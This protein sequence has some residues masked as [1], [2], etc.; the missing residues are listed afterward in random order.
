ML[1]ESRKKKIAL[2]FL[3]LMSAQLLSPLMASALTSGPAQPEMQKFEPAGATDLVD[4]FTGDLKYNI[5]L[6]EVGGYP[7]NLSYHSG[8]GMDEEASWVGTGWTLNPG[9]VNRTLRGLPDEFDGSQMDDPDIVTKEYSRK[10]FE[11]VAG[12]VVLKTTALAWEFGSASVNL[13]VY[14]DNYYGIGASIGASLGYTLARNSQT[15]LTAGLGISSDNR[16]G[17]SVN[18]SLSLSMNQNQSSELGLSGLSGSLHYNT[19]A[20]LKN[21]SLTA[22]FS[23]SYF[24]KLNSPL[25]RT[26]VDVYGPSASFVHEFGQS[27]TPTINVN[28]INESYSFSLDG[29]PTIFGGYIGIGGSGSVFKEKIADKTTKAPAYGYLNYLK[30]YKNENALLDFN[31]EK[32]GVFVPS[33]PSIA[34]PVA[35]YDYF[36]AVSQAGCQQF[37]PYFGGNYIVFDKRNQSSSTHGGAGITTGGGNLIK[38]GAR[39]D[40]NTSKTQTKKWT[41]Q[42]HYL[43]KGEYV[44]SYMP[45]EEPVYFKQVGEQTLADVSFLGQVGGEKTQQ[46]A[47]NDRQNAATDAVAYAAFKSREDGR[48]GINSNIR[49]EGR[50]I[51]NNVFSYLTAKQA[52]W[53]GVDRKIN[54]E[55]RHG[56]NSHRKKHHIS[57]VQVTDNEG[58]RMV[59]GIPVYNIQQDEVSFSIKKPEGAALTQARSTGL[60]AYTPTD[61]SINN[62]NGR[63][64]LFSKESLPAYP[65]SFLLTNILST[66]YVD[67]TGDGVTDDDLGTAVKFNYAKH[68]FNYKWRAPFTNSMANYNEGLQSDP[69]DDKASYVFGEKEVWYLKSIESKTMIAVFETTDRE[70]GLGV[71]GEAGGINTQQKLKKLSRIKLYSKADFLRNGTNAIPIKTVHFEYDYSLYPNILN[72]SGNPLDKNGNPVTPCATGNPNTGIGSDINCQKGKLTLKKVYFTFGT[73]TRGESNP[74]EFFYDTSPIN[75]IPELALIP[76]HN[77]EYTDKYAQRLTDRW[78]TYKKSFYNRTGVNNA[79][80]TNAEFPYV[81]QENDQTPFSEKLLNDKFASK[82]QLN[83]IITTTGSTITI[84]YESDDYAYVQDR[85]A[86]QMC[87]VKGINEV[88]KDTGLIEADSLVIELPKVLTGADLIGQFKNLYLKQNDGRLLDK[89]F[90]KVYADID[91][92]NHYEYINGYAELDLNG[93]RVAGDG[94][95]VSLGLKKVGTYNPV[96]KAAWQM[97]KADLPQYAYDYYD[98]TSVGNGKAAIRSII[99]A[100]GNLSELRVSF[101]ERAKRKGFANKIDLTK[102]MVRLNSPTQSK[103]GGGVRV[104]KVQI[105]DAW[106]EMIGS[107]NA[108]ATYGQ[109]YEYTDKDKNGVVYS[110][111][112]AAYEPHVGNEENPFHEPVSFTEKVHWGIDRYHFI[113]KPFG[114]SYFPA[115]EVGYSKVTVTAIGDDNIQGLP[116]R[117][118]GFAIHEYYTAKDFPTIVDYLPLDYKDA[119]NSLTLALFASV[120]RKNAAVS[121]GF[122][123][124]L[125]DMHGK[126][127]GERIFNKGGDLVSSSEYFYSVKDQNAATKELNNAVDVLQNDDMIQSNALIGVDVDFT[128]DVREST[129]IS[130]GTSIGAYIGSAVFII[131]IPYGGIN[132]N[133]QV[134]SDN[135]NSIATV[136]VIR[137]YGLLKKVVNTQNGSTIASENLLWDGQTGKVILSRTQNE[138]DDYTYAFSYPAYLAYDGMGAAYKNSGIVFLNFSTDNNG[139]IPF[140]YNDYLVPGDELGNLYDNKRGWVIKSEDDS[141]R[142]IDKE[143][144]YIST[145]RDYKLLRSGRRNLLSAEAGKIISMQDP[146]A[147]GTIDGELFKKKIID[148]QAIVYKEQWGLP[149]SNLNRQVTS[150]PGGGGGGGARMAA[151]ESNS[152]GNVCVNP[153]DSVINPYYHNLLGNWH[154]L[155]P[156]I[157]STT[158]KQVPGNTSQNGGTDIRN[159]GYFD[160]FSPFWSFTYDGSSKRILPITDIPNYDNRWLWSSKTIHYDAKGNIVENVDPLNRYNSVLYGF[161]ESVATAVAANARRNEIAFESFEDYDFDLQSQSNIPCPNKKHFDFNFTKTSGSWGNYAGIINSTFAH[162]GKYSY[163]IS[164]YFS[165]F[166]ELGNAAPPSNILGYDIAG[167]Y[168]LKSNEMA[169]GFA[170]IQG[171]KYLLSFWVKDNQPN[172]N[173]VQGLTLT[174]N[175]LNYQLH[176]VIVPVV[177]GWKKVDVTFTAVSYFYME[178]NP[179]GTLYLD[180]FRIIPFDGQISTNVYN[181]KNL[182][183]MAQLD[184]NNFATYF[185]Y[186]DEG[187]PIRV[188]KETEKGVM[189][190]KENRQ[191]VRGRF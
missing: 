55:D 41:N 18:P 141:L 14:K 67:K 104:R 172:N 50:E 166:M 111:G 77:E 86:M 96:A 74:Y 37:R 116:Q 23:N 128:T 106:G 174:V 136:K 148:A 17:V 59:Y 21:Y 27:Y 31:R 46:V 22:S 89:I 4:L 175:G 47:I 6:L 13:N 32:D 121:H 149:I 99:Q 62:E 170:P 1:R 147:Y 38:G 2:F 34:I 108:T 179:S 144:N 165:R 125:N 20:G 26:A 44:P 64:W 5:P 153:I 68:D 9:A 10:P 134:T 176:N 158:R 72:N 97:L 161:Q 3:L 150:P 88:G 78:G 85:K 188:K 142:L 65:T 113:E 30:G 127:K 163:Q 140:F 107:Q 181:D 139:L 52:Y 154:S 189:T 177:E 61:A 43:T 168:I 173:K 92:R 71:V 190:L 56:A 183:L 48:V 137:K 184:E 171:K 138:Y 167:R 84:D 126:Q 155:S 63:D 119:S 81:I 143:G 100:I 118:T 94:K 103:M 191:A 120:S 75:A 49:K 60:I 51:K 101:D 135:Y 36:T 162:T 58:K 146:R 54:G 70:D 122:K 83:K 156:Y 7:V 90:Y 79:S 185:E 42:N 19:R 152:S 169:N 16:Q 57:E 69:L 164:S 87:F 105:S 117:T 112:V 109:L 151:L 24:S 159:S 93:I 115:P 53:H 12:Q 29:G 129:N 186:D 15:P 73:S 39:I 187:T 98:N 102:S 131:P 145:S 33:A 45:D 182:R 124:E 130:I 110:S 25:N 8:T 178:L 28:T 76:A 11:K 66:D 91:N 35:T 123:L 95:S 157:Y 82:W 114:E 132:F 160:T 40:I 80:L 180:D 133:A